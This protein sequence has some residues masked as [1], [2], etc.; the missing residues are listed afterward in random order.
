MK[1]ISTIAIA[2]LLV[3]NINFVAFAEEASGK[4][5]QVNILFSEVVLQILAT[6]ILILVI[7]K[8]AWSKLLE[9]IEER[10]KHVNDSITKAQTA[11]D[12]AQKLEQSKEAE[13]VELKSSK[14]EIL[15]NSKQEAKKEY[16]EIVNDAKQKAAS[17]LEKSNKEIQSQQQEVQSQLSKELAQMS[18]S[19]AQKFLK[20][21]MT[22]QLEQELIKQ[23]L[24]EVGNE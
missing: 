5:P 16:D 1:K 18:V 13:L 6:I 19:V 20:E 24:Q 15:D 3:F 11:K 21:N 14:K 12:N 2:L 7:K 22:E 9:V 10:K 8:F 23:A 4:Q 17:I